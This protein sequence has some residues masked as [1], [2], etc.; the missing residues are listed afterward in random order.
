[1]LNLLNQNTTFQAYL[2]S[3]K[4]KYVSVIKMGH[5]SKFPGPIELME[6]FFS[7]LLMPDHCNVEPK[8]RY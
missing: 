2:K 7:N 5:Y 1:M 4:H 6:I 8:S 3:L